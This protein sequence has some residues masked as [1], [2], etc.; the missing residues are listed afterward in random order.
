MI[1]YT[2]HSLQIWEQQYIR[3]SHVASYTSSALIKGI[4]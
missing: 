3:L 1:L 2:P 4:R